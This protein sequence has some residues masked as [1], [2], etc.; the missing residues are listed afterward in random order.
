[1]TAVCLA[2]LVERGL[3]DPSRTVCSYWPE[4]S[5]AGKSDVTV[6]ELLS[7]RAGLPVLDGPVAFEEALDS[8]H[9]AARLAAQAP[10]WAPGTV[11]GYHAFTFGALADALV[12]RLTRRSV[13]SFLAH[14]IA[15]PLGADLFIGLPESEFRRLAPLVDPIPQTRDEIAQAVS[16]PAE[17]SA[18]LALFDDMSDP[19]S[20]SMR[21][22]TLNGALS[23]H[24]SSRSRQFYA[25]EIPA[26]NGI[27]NARALARLYAS[28]VTKVDGCRLLSDATLDAVAAEQASGPDAVLHF[29]TRFAVGFQLDLPNLPMLSPSS[30]GHPGAG[31][32]LGFADRE[33]NVGFGYVQN[34]Q[35]GFGHDLRTRS[36]ILALRRSLT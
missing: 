14:E 6:S 11:H 16:D 5:A 15:T 28:C 13:G 9:L 4:F 3:L 32:A 21:G 29:P 33:F 18:V 1:M 25:A 20:L 30:F 2:L 10:I 19:L 17:R 34:Q 22:G 27:T 7:H 36:L 35:G 12:R 31:G 26:A 24:R 23:G 8:T